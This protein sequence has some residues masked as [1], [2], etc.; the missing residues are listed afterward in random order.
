MDFWMN[1]WLDGGGE[2]RN[3][4][5]ALF[6]RPPFLLRK[7]Y[8]GQV[9]LHQDYGATGRRMAKCCALAALRNFGGFVPRVRAG[10]ALQLGCNIS[11]LQPFGKES[12]RVAESGKWGWFASARH[13][14]RWRANAK[15]IFWDVDPG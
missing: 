10:L 12:G 3:T 2:R 11:G 15:R 5:K 13:P 4:P 7:A 1:G 14:R 8:R 6:C 9:R